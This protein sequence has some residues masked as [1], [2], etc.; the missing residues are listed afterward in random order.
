MTVH[1]RIVPA[2]VFPRETRAV[3]A[4]AYPE[5]PHKLDHRL[6]QHQLL[7]LGALAELGEVLPERS[8]EYNRGDLAL[9]IDGKPDRTGRPIGETIRQIDTSN[10]WAVLKNIEQHPSYASLLGELLGELASDIVPRT[11][12]MMKTQGFI[13]VSSPNAVTPYHFDPEHNILLQLVGEKAMTVFPAADPRFAPDSVHETYHT[14]GGREL[15]WRDELADDG[16]VFALTP[17]DALY[18]PVM[19][20]HHVRNGPQPSISLSIT[21]RSEWSYAEA[22]ARA[23]NGLLRRIGL[24]PRPPGRWPA[25]NTAKAIGW[26]M[27]RRVPGIVD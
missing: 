7:T 1:G 17:G 20:P 9:G 22:D 15:K 2:E 5:I 21:W 16:A 6:D 25:R 27:A 19:A 8:V 3:F 4:G 24:E 14:G 13:F 18:V 10:S 11:G 23:F 12:R 26:R